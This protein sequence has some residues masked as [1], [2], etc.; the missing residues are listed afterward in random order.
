MHIKFLIKGS[1]TFA[2]HAKVSSRASLSILCGH[3][4]CFLSLCF[5]YNYSF[6]QKEERKIKRQQNI[7]ETAETEYTS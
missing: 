5:Q 3:L 2:I 4:S 1:R 7:N 6:Q